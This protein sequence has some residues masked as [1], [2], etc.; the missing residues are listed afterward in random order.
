MS[1]PDPCILYDGWA[2]VY[3]P[4]SPAALHL[5]TLLAAH[6]PEI[7][8]CLA[9]PGASFHPLPELL[10]TVQVQV[11]N[12]PR[13]RLAWEQR[14]LPGLARRLRAAAIHHTGGAPALFGALPALLSP[15][16]YGGLEP[17]TWPAPPA[18]AGPQR[19][20]MTER[21]RLALGQGGI[22]RL[23]SLLWPAD[24]PAPRVGLP[25]QLLPPVVH[26]AWLQ[27][28][29]LDRRPASAPGLPETYILYAGPPSP[30]A[31][32]QVLEAWSWAAGS[33]GEYYPL[34]LLGLDLRTRQELPALVA[35]Y[36]LEQN[37]VRALPDLPLPALVELYRAASA[38]FHPTFDSPWAGSLRLA[39][40]AGRPL[41]A[42]ETPQSDALVGSAAYLVP[43]RQGQP[44][45]RALGAALITVVVEE[46]VAERLAQAA[47]ARAQTWRLAEFSQSLA[48]FY[49][50]RLA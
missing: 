49:Q 15:A 7:T 13:A 21:L 2:L 23:A 48:E 25:I 46:V 16:G 20:A 43:P 45:S 12:Q 8:A 39:L 4:V 18:L 11:A 5:L 24:L 33:L 19:L 14:I 47:W 34:L 35:R 26:P 10:R 44:D 1:V 3:A 30:Q 42:L 27:A 31:L 32:A 40:A 6:P 28:L 22:S 29:D 38:V 36:R 41:V 37:S 9:L 50:Q 17:F